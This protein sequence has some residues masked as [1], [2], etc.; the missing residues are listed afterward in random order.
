MINPRFLFSIVGGLSLVYSVSQCAISKWRGRDDQWASAGGALVTALA[1]GLACTSFSLFLH[2]P[3]HSFH[4]FYMYAVKNPNQTLIMAFY[5]PLLAYFLKQ[6]YMDPRYAQPSL[7]YYERK[8]HRVQCMSPAVQEEMRDGYVHR[9]LD[10][11]L[12]RMGVKVPE[13]WRQ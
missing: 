5:A 12:E 6:A 11:Q 7:S 13:S 8:A 10:P 9:W 1:A 2:A 3:T 4:L